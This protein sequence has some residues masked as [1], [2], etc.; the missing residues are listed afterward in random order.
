[1]LEEEDIYEYLAQVRIAGC[2]GRD[3]VRC[4]FQFHMLLDEHVN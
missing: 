4:I 2:F 3:V 1:M